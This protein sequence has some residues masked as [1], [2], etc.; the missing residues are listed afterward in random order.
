LFFAFLAFSVVWLVCIGNAKRLT[1]RLPD[2]LK[3]G[4]FHVLRRRT[5]DAS[6]SASLKR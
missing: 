1:A 5:R 6:G 4:E 3:R 2:A